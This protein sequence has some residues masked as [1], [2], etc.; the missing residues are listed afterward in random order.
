MSNDTY[1]VWRRSDGFVSATT[2]R[3]RNWVTDGTEWAFEVLLVTKDWPEARARIEEKRKRPGARTTETMSGTIRRL[4]PLVASGA[5]AKDDAVD[6]I[7]DMYQP[8]LTRR[9]VADLVEHL[10]LRES[11]R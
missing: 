8:G 1:V 10:H 7:I 9:A 3:P 6:Q 2:F 4:G 5:L 11:G